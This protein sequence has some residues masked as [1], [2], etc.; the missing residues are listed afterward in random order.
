[1]CGSARVPST[2][3]ANS[4]TRCDRTTAPS[5]SYT[6]GRSAATGATTAPVP[7][8]PLTSSPRITVARR[9]T[10]ARGPA[11][12]VVST[13]VPSALT[14]SASAP[15]GSNA[16]SMPGANLRTVAGPRS[17]N[18]DTNDQGGEYAAGSKT[19]VLPARRRAGSQK[20]ASTSDRSTVVASWT[21]TVIRSA[22]PNA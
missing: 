2:V 15:A 22:S 12:T 21:V 5:G 1:M 20:T 18:V 11:Q 19:R 14:H 10:R 9:A 6:Y 3:V 8:S 13:T 17:T 16:W 7:T 4:A